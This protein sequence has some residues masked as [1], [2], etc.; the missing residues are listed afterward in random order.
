MKRFFDDKIL[1]LNNDVI[2][3]EMIKILMRHEIL[4]SE[5]PIIWKESMKSSTKNLI[6]Q[7]LLKSFQDLFPLNS[8]TFQQTLTS[9]VNSSFHLGIEVFFRCSVFLVL[10]LSI[11]SS[12]YGLGFRNPLLRSDA[13]S[14]VKIVENY[15]KIQN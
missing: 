9:T 2:G 6:K 15:V 11:I 4:T 3:L 12:T 14:T 7:K 5:I 13:C 1:K 8:K 10:L